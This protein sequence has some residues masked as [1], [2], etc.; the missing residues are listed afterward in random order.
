M[1]VVAFEGKEAVTIARN[2]MGATFG[3]KGRTGH[4][5]R[6]ISASATPSIS[7]TDRTR[8]KPLRRKSRCYFQPGDIVEWDPDHSELGLRYE[9]R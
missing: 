6:G 5:S 7:Y 8:P 4:D 1:V 9:Q 3:S 2:L